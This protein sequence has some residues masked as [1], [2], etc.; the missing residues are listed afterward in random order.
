MTALFIMAKTWKQPKCLSIS[1]WLTNY[2]T[3]TTWNTTQQQ[4]EQSTDIYNNL[5]K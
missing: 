3:F 2:G 5:D 1:E 4:K